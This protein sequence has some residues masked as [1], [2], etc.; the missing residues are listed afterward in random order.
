MREKGRAGIYL[1]AAIYMFYN[2][3]QVFGFRNDNNGNEFMLMVIFSIVFL[4]AGIALFAVSAIIMKKIRA[5]EKKMFLE[6]K[7]KK[8]E[9]KTE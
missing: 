1:I 3:Y 4:V 8:E 2:A 5:E 7:Q 9:E 6:Q